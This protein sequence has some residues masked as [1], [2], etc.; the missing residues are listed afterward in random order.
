M[1]LVVVFLLFIG[2]FLLY[3]SIKQYTKQCPKNKIEYRFIPRT[4][5]E[6]QENPVLPSKIFASMFDDTTII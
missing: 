5:Q 1:E 4:F 6:E 2:L 3:I